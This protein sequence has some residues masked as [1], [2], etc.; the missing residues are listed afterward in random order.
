MFF[1]SKNTVIVSLPQTGVIVFGSL[2]SGISRE[3]LEE[4]AL[5]SS[6]MFRLRFGAVL[7]A[8]PLAW[9]SVV[10]WLSVRKEVS[11]IVKNFVFSSGL[12]LLVAL[13]GFIGYA[14]LNPMID[15]D[16]RIGDSILPTTE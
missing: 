5:P 6:T 7:L 16:W 14:V 13:I 1:T 3:M 12:I 4:V 11:D 10:L 9:I 15:A 2:A 8:L